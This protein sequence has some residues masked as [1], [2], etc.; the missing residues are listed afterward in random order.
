MENTLEFDDHL[1]HKNGFN[2]KKL[3]VPYTYL[4]FSIFLLF[5]GI[6]SYQ[7]PRSFYEETHFGP[8]MFS[9]ILISFGT[10]L[11]ILLCIFYT[12]HNIVYVMI[13]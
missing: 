13:F 4:L 8:L 7:S 3:L 1:S 2:I 10:I 9:L 6:S 11:T 5:T 12:N